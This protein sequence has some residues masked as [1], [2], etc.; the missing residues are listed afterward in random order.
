M[1]RNLINDQDYKLIV[2]TENLKNHN[3]HLKEQLDPEILTKYSIIKENENTIQQSYYENNKLHA[4]D[5]TLQE[6]MRLKE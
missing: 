3:A 6:N 4:E 5:I 2:E 1:V